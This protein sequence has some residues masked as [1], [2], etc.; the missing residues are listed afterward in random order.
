MSQVRVDHNA[1]NVN[2]GST[3]VFF[4]EN[5]T[6][7]NFYGVLDHNTLSSAGSVMLTQVIG[8]MNN[9]PPPSPFGTAN[10]LFVEDNAITITK[11]TNN[12]FGCMDSWGSAAIVWRH[13]TSLNCLVTAHGALHAGGPQNI[14]L[15]SNRLQGDNNTTTP[16]G[17]RLF[18]H[19]GSGSFIAFDNL[20]TA[21]KGKS[22]D[23]LAVMY[24]RSASSTASGDLCD[25]NNSKDG[26]RSPITTYRGYPC[27]HQP[28]RDFRANLLPIY[29]WNNRWSDTNGRVDLNMEDYGGNFQAQFVQDRDYYIGV[30]PQTSQTVPFSG[31]TDM[32][33]GLL[34]LRPTSCSIGRTDAG[35]AGKGGVGYYA[36]DTSTLYRCASANTWIAHYTPYTYPHPLTAN[37]TPPPPVDTTKPSTPA[38]LIATATSST[39]INLSW[40]ISTDDVAVTGYQVSRGGSLVATVPSSTY[41]DTGLTP[42]T[43][44]SYT[45]VAMDA[46]GNLSDPSTVAMTTTEA[47]SGGGGNSVFPGAIFDCSPRTGPVPL[48]V[49][50]TDESTGVPTAWAWN[51]GDSGTSTDSTETNPAHTYTQPGTYAVRS[52]VSNSSGVA[53]ATKNSYVVTSKALPSSITLL[54]T[55]TPD[56]TNQI[57]CTGAS[58]SYE[59]GA[60]FQSTVA[61]NITGIRFWKASNERDTH[62]GRLWSATGTQLATGT[63]SNETASGW[64]TLTLNTPVAITANTT[65]VVTVNTG[66]NYYVISNTG[67]ATQITNQSLQSVVG[68]NGVFGPA[69]SFPTMNWMS[70]NYFRDVVF[71]PN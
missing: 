12:G 61:G 27:W 60:K 46:A 24:Y 20:F 48:I 15:Y 14:E 21:T 8:G 6:I 10:N 22:S 44:Y 49:T 25:G 39:A 59:L 32:G 9:S 17:T 13:N 18:H 65:Y 3:A 71:Q 62:T 45:V 33:Y 37:D 7:A 26:N 40:T 66:A 1:F 4:G 23:A 43:S 63:F 29:S 55:Q 34:N 70:A 67:F 64:Q 42:S 31:A 56:N 41:Q 35:D 69:G 52:T 51:F 19:Q 53:S 54:T 68:T 16:D 28:G 30:G 58:C 50:C 47:D 2:T 38:G 5:T 11:M 57:D 36:T